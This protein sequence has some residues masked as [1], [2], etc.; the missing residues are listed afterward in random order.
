MA[1]KLDVTTYV[2]KSSRPVVKN[3]HMITALILTGIALT[4]YLIGRN[5]KSRKPR[6]YPPMEAS[7]KRILQDKVV[8]Y[9]KLNSTEKVQFEQRILHFIATTKIT[10]VQVDVALD[11]KLLV[12]AGAII[13]VFHFPGW[14]YFNL[15]EVLLYPGLFDENFNTEGRGRMISGMVGRGVMEGKMILS[16]KSLHLGFDNTTDKKNVA[17]HEFIHL[18]DKA[19]GQIDGVPSLLVNRAF[20]LPW[21]ELIRHKIKEIER[22]KSDINS[23]GATSVEEFFPVSAEYFFERPKLLKRKHPK[24]YAELE[25]IFIPERA[26]KTT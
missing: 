20:A 11:D 3:E 21:L 10:G 16:K 12:A 1:V 4:V 15:N 14:E 9:S 8:F 24:L 5:K 13:P 7:S 19:D 22:K 6:E 26:K 18:I 25:E 2:S 23:Y 17:I